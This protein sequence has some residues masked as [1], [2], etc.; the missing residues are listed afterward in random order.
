MYAYMHAYTPVYPYPSHADKSRDR[1]AETEAET[2][3]PRARQIS[4]AEPAP[5]AVPLMNVD[6]S[7]VC[8][9]QRPYPPTT[10]KR[11]EKTPV[12]THV[13]RDSTVE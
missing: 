10:T 9:H 6:E 1:Q 12:T 5:T 2:Q 7:P 3:V 11:R 13:S 4:S 8:L